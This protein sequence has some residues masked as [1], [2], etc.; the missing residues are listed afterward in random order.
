[1]EKLVYPVWKN[2]DESGDAFRDRLLAEL[3]PALSG[4]SNVRRVQFNVVDSA[5]DAAVNDRQTASQPPIDGM[6]QVWVNTAVFR[7]EVEKLLE[8]HLTRFTGYLVTESEP[9]VNDKHVT[10]DGERTP[11][12]S[13][14]V[15]L[16][17][18]SWM[19]HAA[20]LEYWQGTHSYVGINTQANFRYVQNVVARPMTYAA[21]VYHAIVEEGFPTD[22][23]T[24]K[25]VFYDAVGDD[26]KF[27]KNQQIMLDS[28]AKFIQFDKIDCIPT[29]EYIIKS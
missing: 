29:S 4:L 13:Q 14:V 23:M 6:V 22:A 11:G 10:P 28:C 1:M 19:N 3:A 8:Q 15:F 25:H 24:D 21:P 16:Q 5:V 18:P 26:E 2:S 17:V 7:S 12:Y 9:I 20:W 27:Q